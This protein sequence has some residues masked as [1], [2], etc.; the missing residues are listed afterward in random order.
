MRAGSSR[1]CDPADRLPVSP[2]DPWGPPGWRSAD[3]TPHRPI[4]QR[5]ATRR[6][7]APRLRCGLRRSLDLDRGAAAGLLERELGN[8]TTDAGRVF[9]RDPPLAGREE[10]LELG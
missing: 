1:A 8:G 5:R 4:G 7:D 10:Q 9:G 2:A 3:P 6:F